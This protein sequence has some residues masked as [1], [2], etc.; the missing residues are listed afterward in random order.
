MVGLSVVMTLDLELR[1]CVRAMGVLLALLNVI[2][3]LLIW[4]EMGVLCVLSNAMEVSVL[5]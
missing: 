4:F 2:G 1:V 5:P 3:V